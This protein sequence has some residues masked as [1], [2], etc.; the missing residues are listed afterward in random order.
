MI[1][2]NFKITRIL[3]VALTLGMLS[4]TATGD[5][6]NPGTSNTKISGSNLGPNGGGSID[7]KIKQGYTLVGLGNG[8]SNLTFKF[9]L[10]GDGMAAFA[11]KADTPKNKLKELKNDLEINGENFEFEV[12]Y[13]NFNSDQHELNITGLKKGDVVNLDSQAIDQDGKVVGEKKIDDKKVTRDDETVDVNISLSISISNTNTNTNNVTQNNTQTVNANP[14]IIVNLPSPPPMQTPQPQA[15]SSG[16]SSSN[17][18]CLRPDQNHKVTF[19]GTSY[20][21]C[22]PPGETQT[23]GCTRPDPNRVVTTSNGKTFTLCAPN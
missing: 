8:S 6:N 19:E 21:I 14:T 23:A 13:E 9:K 3:F 7:P 11:T 20:Q 16:S 2:Q 4:C 15:S 5:L 17:S 22:E 10:T 12:P 1:R 18:S